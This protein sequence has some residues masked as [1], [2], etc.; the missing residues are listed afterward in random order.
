MINDTDMAVELISEEAFKGL[1]CY[2]GHIF[3][4]SLTATYGTV[5]LDNCETLTSV[6]LSAVS[7]PGLRLSFDNCPELVEVKFPENLN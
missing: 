6:D 5:G 2:V 4:S 7:V 3:P 1:P